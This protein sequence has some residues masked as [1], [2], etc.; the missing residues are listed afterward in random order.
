MTRP[1]CCLV[2]PAVCSL[3]V[4]G[5]CCTTLSLN[6]SMPTEHMLLCLTPMRKNIVT[7]LGGNRKNPCR[8]VVWH[9]SHLF[10]VGQL[11]PVFDMDHSICTL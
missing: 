5:L 9:G 7:V 3:Y 8:L 2:G 4:C 1:V 10:R 6:S 11:P